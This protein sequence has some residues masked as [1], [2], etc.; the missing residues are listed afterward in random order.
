MKK[1]RYL[2]KQA[3]FQSETSLFFTG[4]KISKEEMRNKVDYQL[5]K[6]CF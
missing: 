6:L 4:H 5:T 3:L 1:F 2:V